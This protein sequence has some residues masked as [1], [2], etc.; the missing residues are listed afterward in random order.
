MPMTAGSETLEKVRVLLLL[1]L[2]EIA[3]IEVQLPEDTSR[4]GEEEK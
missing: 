3:G 2:N 1:L 4:I